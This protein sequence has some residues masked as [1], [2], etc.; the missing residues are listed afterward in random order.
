MPLV[1]IVM[2]MGMVLVGLILVIRQNALVTRCAKQLADDIGRVLAV[3]GSLGEHRGLSRIL[4]SR[5]HKKA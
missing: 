1:I 5:C 4:S 2:V 3:L